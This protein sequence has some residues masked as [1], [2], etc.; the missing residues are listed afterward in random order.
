ML[1]ERFLQRRDN[2][3]RDPGQ[4]STFCFAFVM[5]D[6]CQGKTGAKLAFQLS[7]N[8]SWDTTAPLFEFSFK[9]SAASTA[10]F[11]VHKRLFEQN[12]S[13]VNFGYVMY[14]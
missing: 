8:H 11:A 2:T 6:E 7:Q 13:P 10:Q 5:S 3:E 4:K 14:E 1:Y 12:Q 9:P